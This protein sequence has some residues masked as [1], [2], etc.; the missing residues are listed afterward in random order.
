MKVFS[1]TQLQRLPGQLTPKCSLEVTASNGLLRLADPK[2]DEYFKLGQQWPLSNEPESHLDEIAERICST[3][4]PSSIL[5]FSYKDHTLSERLLKTNP[6]CQV[7]TLTGPDSLTASSPEYL[8]ATSFYPLEA[9]KAS[10]ELILIRHFLEHTSEPYI[11]ISHLFRFLKPGGHIYVEVPLVDYFIERSNPLFL[12]EQHRI[13][14]TNTLLHDFLLSASCSPVFHRMYGSDIEPSGCT[15]VTR[16]KLPQIVSGPAVPGDTQLS[17]LSELPFKIKLLTYHFSEAWFNYLSSRTGKLAIFGLG[18]AS[19]R[20]IQ[21]TRSQDIIHYYV[22]GDNAK[23]GLYLPGLPHPIC[24]LGSIDLTSITTFI[25][26]VHA[27]DSRRVANMLKDH[28][29]LGDV[30]SIYELPPVESYI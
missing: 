24:S 20:F 19:H 21:F 26:G 16:C 1:F 6:S 9:V 28:G 29:F 15:L 7:K 5:C 13:Y 3:C 11:L 17:N 4:S 18:H 27:R 2:P 22:D 30:F 14:F 23:A 12:W 25:L 8:T 10:F